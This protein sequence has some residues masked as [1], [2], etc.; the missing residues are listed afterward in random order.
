[1]C[2]EDDIKDGQE[3]MTTVDRKDSE[4]AIEKPV[5]VVRQ[6]PQRK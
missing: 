4:E 2:T 1:M 6:L 5:G 3:R